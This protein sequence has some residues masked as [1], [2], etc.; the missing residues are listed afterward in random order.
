MKPASDSYGFFGRH[1][2]LPSFR[3]DLPSAARADFMLLAGHI[4]E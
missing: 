2:W 1:I 3:T 4:A